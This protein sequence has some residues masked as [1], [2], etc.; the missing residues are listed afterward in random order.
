MARVNRRGGERKGKKRMT[1]EKTKK[2][3]GWREERNQMEDRKEMRREE[4]NFRERY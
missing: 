3:G 4:N 2:R 1:D